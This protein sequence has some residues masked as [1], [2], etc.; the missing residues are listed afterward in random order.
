MIVLSRE[1]AGRALGLGPLDAPVEGVCTDSRRVRPGDLFVALRGERFDG[2]DFVAEALSKGACGAIVEANWWADRGA[3]MIGS[4]PGT[5]ALASERAE[6]I[7]P[8]DDTLRALGWLARDVRRKSATKVVAVTGSVGKTS[9]KD[10][11]NAMAA[12]VCRVVGTSANQNNEVG[13]PLTLLGIEPDTD[14][15]IVEMGMRGPGQI[16][17]LARVAEPDVGVVTNIYP[18]HLELLG[19]L[20]NIAKAKAELLVCLRP[21]ALA[22]IPADCPLL[23]PYAAGVAC[24]VV[25]F[26]FGSGSGGG[27]AADVSGSFLPGEAQGKGVLRLRWPEGQAEVEVPFASRHRLENAVAAAAACYAAELPVERC[28]SGLA[29]ACFSGSRGDVLGVPGLTLI[30]DTYNASPAAVRAA[31][32]DLVE[33]AGEV[34]GR[35]VAVLG[36]MLELGPD[37]AAYHEATGAYAAEA[38]VA[39]LWGVGPLSVS[40][41]EGFRRARATGTADTSEESIP[42]LQAGNVGSADEASPILAD[43][44]RGDV[45]LLKASRSM[46]LEVLV[47]RIKKEAAAGRW[48]GPSGAD[49]DRGGTTKG[50]RA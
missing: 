12:R 4:A 13:V 18:V 14:L 28:V 26:A 20:E 41:V 7:Y 21:D 29:N 1:E 17:A 39:A 19:T 25:R 15:A 42:P 32:D 44:R 3:R 43:L 9:T 10:L 11:L 27:E 8:V 37:T 34:A 40:T 38:G 36:D 47:R 5:T 33:L 45:V 31:L 35:P 50:S 46:G 23:A 48:A 49:V 24:R 2:H 30:D 22:V 16:G 6:I